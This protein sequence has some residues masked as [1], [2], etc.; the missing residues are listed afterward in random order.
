M[1]QQTCR[2][3]CSAWLE[4]RHLTIVTHVMSFLSVQDRWLPC[5][6]YAVWRDISAPQS[7]GQVLSNI[8]RPDL[9]GVHSLTMRKYIS[10]YRIYLQ[11]PSS[12][13]Q[14]RDISSDSACSDSVTTPMGKYYPILAGLK[15]WCW[16]LSAAQISLGSFGHIMVLIQ[17]WDISGLSHQIR[18]LSRD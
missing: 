2:R 9:A 4:E 18:D 13:R 1:L 15:L 17:P 10:S 8:R 7:N 12:W 16:N 5:T 11:L 3:S 6:G 14:L